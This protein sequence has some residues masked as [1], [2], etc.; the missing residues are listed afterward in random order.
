MLRRFALCG[1]AATAIESRAQTAT[2]A[3][4]LPEQ[5][6]ED[7][8]VLSPFEVQTD[9]DVGYTATSALAGG[10]TNTPLKQTPAAV[11]VMTREFIDDVGGTSFRQLAEWGVNSVPDYNANQSPFGDYAINLRGMGSSFPSM[12]YFLWYIDG[13]GYNTERFEIA[14]GPNGVLFGDGNIG[15]IAT[16]WTKRARVDRAFRN[17]SLRAD[18]YGGYRATLDLNQPVGKDFA[19]RLNTVYDHSLSWRDNSDNDRTGAHLAGTL[20][21]GDRSTFRF[22]VEGGTRETN[23][24]ATNYGDWSSYW[25]GTTTYDGVTAPTG[26]GVGRFSGGVYN[27]YIPAVP[28]AGF[29]NWGPMY[30]TNGTGIAIRPDGRADIPNSPRLPSREFNLQPKDSIVELEYYTYSL[31]LDHR[32]G[33]NLYAQVAYNRSAND[34]ESLHS[35]TLFQDYR[36]DVNRVLPNGQ[37]NPKFGVPFADT[38]RNTQN[39]TNHLDDLRLLLTYGFDTSWLKQRISVIGG[40]RQDNFDYWQARLYR[41]NG[42]NP[43]YSSSDNQYYERRY[44]D[45]PGKYDLGEPPVL[46]GYTFGYQPTF[47]MTQRKN[48]DYAQV[49]ATS[50][51]FDERLTVLL[52]LRYDHVYQKQQSSSGVPVDPITGLPRLGGVIY[53]PGQLPLGVVGGRDKIDVEPVSKNAGA[54]YYLTRWLGIYGNY[55][56]TFQPPGAG[57]NLVDGRIPDISRS[58]GYDLGFKLDFLDGKISGSIN[59]YNTQQTDRL[60]F[61]NPRTTEINRIWTNLGRDD[62]AVVTFR[63][64]QTYKGTGYEAEFTANPTRNLTIMFNYALPETEAIDILPGLRSYYDANV[65]TWQAGAND[66]ANPNRSL[67]QQDIDAIRGQLTSSVPGV[68]L[69]NTYK[70]TGNVYATYTFRDGW[71]KDFS[72]GAGANLRGKS[73]IGSTLASPFEYMY[74]AS[75]EIYSAHVAYRYRFDKVVARFQVNVSNI[76]DNDDLIAT[77]TGDYRVGGLGTNPLIRTESGFRYIDPRRFTFTATFEF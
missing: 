67:I 28:Q 8:V 55:A 37:P 20:R 5:K 43:R 44:W 47:L 39:Q 35:E 36:I 60:D 42:T 50:Q 10:R 7:P 6:P 30:R 71:L 64:T 18:T 9:R 75:H 57:A 3:P 2:A 19:L 27:V 65:A 45:E 58:E 56:E 51:F 72:A 53:R 12:N 26:G 16:T 76:F 49:A 59:Y 34:R 46:P 54:V 4:E 69:N 32:F 15:G 73:K 70:Y 48:L 17:L 14:R 38:Q 22:E 41:T 77:G 13:D 74:G 31:Y 25:D 29:G 40:L 33:D 62:L 23:V 66:S 21:L 63:D 1:L 24:Y 61:R 68:T 52:G 11:S